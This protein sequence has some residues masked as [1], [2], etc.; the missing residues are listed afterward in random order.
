[1][2][3]TRGDY[4][5]ELRIR[6]IHD[7]FHLP[8][9]VLEKVLRATFVYVFLIVA[10][11][12]AGKREMAQLSSADFIVLIAVANAV[13]NAIIGE[14]NSVTGGVIGAVTL[15]TLNGLLAVLLFKSVRAKKVLEGT[16]TKLIENGQVDHDALRREHISLSE[17]MVAVQRQN[18]D[19]IAE[20]EEASLVPGGAILVK[21][22]ADG[23]DATIDELSR[24]LDQ[25]LA[26]LDAASLLTRSMDSVRRRL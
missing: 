23:Q 3:M 4:T 2:P 1:M 10:L 25:V 8:I 6:M 17:L 7:M 11:R 9:P 15:F 13:Q 20:V 12:L 16:E 5:A 21:R 22:R 24:K 14:D 19:S 18:A 26:R